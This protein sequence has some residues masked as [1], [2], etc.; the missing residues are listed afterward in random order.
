MHELAHSELN[1]AGELARLVGTVQDVTE[2]VENQAAVV[3]ARDE[4][5]RANKAKSEFLSSMS[6]ELRTPLNAILGFGQLIQGDDSLDEYHK[7]SV[8]EIINAGYHLLELINEVLDLSRVESGKIDLSLE[9]VEICPV[10]DECLSL[11]GPLADKREITISHTGVKGAVMRA[12][13]TRLKQALLNLLSNAI[14][15]NNRKGSVTLNMQLSDEN[16]V[17]LY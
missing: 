9:P 8:D 13:R 3:K 11:I 16:Q 5:E 1:E 4:A 10:V 15:Y 17:I 7:E 6:H 2:T 14:K 12:D